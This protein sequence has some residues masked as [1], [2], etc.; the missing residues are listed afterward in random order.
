[1]TNRNKYKK[2]VV[3]TP[4]FY[5]YGAL[6]ITGI[7][8]D[9]D[10]NTTLIKGFENNNQNHEITFISLQ[11]TIH[12]IKYK[13]EIESIKGITIIGGPITRDPSIILNNLNVDIVVL[14]EGEDTIL[15]IMKKLEKTNDKNNLYNIDGIAYL[16][17]DNEIIIN[18]QKTKPSINRSLPYVPSDINKEQIRGANTYIET[19]RGCSGH[20]SF[21]QVP[22]FFGREI[23]SRKTEDIIKEVKYFKNHGAERIAISGGTGTLYGS[24]DFRINDDQFTNLLKEI[25]NITKPANLTI[26]DIR[27]DLVTPKT[28]NA[29]KK[30]TNQWVFYGIESGSQRILKK[31][32]KGIT[33]DQINNA[34]DLARFA[35]LKIAGS[36]IVAYP[37]ETEE[38][39]DQTLDLVADLSL[40]DYFISIAEPIPGTQ[41]AKDIKD[42]PDEENLLYQKS[43]KYKKENYSVAEERALD[44][45]IESYIFRSH[46]V[47][48]NKNLLNTLKDEVKQQHEHITKVMKLY[49]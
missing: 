26:P 10:Y 38:D 33:L 17:N 20:C 6:L 49:K 42:Y 4:E 19:H 46:P 48:M 23:R 25:S 27:V 40:D 47:M 29:I 3:I 16:N 45:M 43:K 35:G 9:N 5:N 12:I 18:P 1:M 2:T 34:V 7:L 14:G 13:K 15:E 11:S 30:Y 32:K 21:C 31:M 41:L 8:K 37:G 36:F 28:L 24:K 39:F 44:L 22:C